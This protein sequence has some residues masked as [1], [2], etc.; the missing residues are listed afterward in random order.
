MAEI[1]QNKIDETVDKLLSTDNSNELYSSVECDSEELNH[2]M[3]RL[4]ELSI[5]IQTAG[6]FVN[7]T[8]RVK[9]FDWMHDID[10]LKCQIGHLKNDELTNVKPSWFR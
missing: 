1:D 4:K 8:Q 7:E 9:F 2:I 10:D 3:K 5:D 6:C